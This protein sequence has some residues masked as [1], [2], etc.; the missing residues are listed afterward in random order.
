LT[1]IRFHPDG[2]YVAVGDYVGK[3]YYYHNF[4]NAKGPTISSKHWHSNR[5]N[6]LEFTKD[7]AFLLSGGKEAVVVLWHQFT[8]QNSFIS[9]VGNEIVNLS[10]S[11]DG[12]LIMIS[13]ADNSVKI[14]KAQNYEIVQH[15]RG[16]LVEPEHTKFVQNSKLAYV[17]HF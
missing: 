7:N 16:L 4:S 9:R 15:F 2:T 11:E 13:M 3:I 6:V 17:Y 8:Q 10:T 1:S 12:T 5:V 14:V